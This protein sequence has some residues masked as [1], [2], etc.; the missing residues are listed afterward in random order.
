MPRQGFS[1]PLQGF[2]VACHAMPYP[3]HTLPCGRALVATQDMSMTCLL[4]QQKTC[5]LFSSPEAPGAD[6][7]VHSLRFPPEL[8]PDMFL[9]FFSDVSCETTGFETISEGTRPKIVLE[10]CVLHEAAMNK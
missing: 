5:L 9:T 3:C 7:D 4:W 1:V 6:P 10:V 8:S 2:S